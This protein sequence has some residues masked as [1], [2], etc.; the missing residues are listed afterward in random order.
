M[1]R[2]PYWNIDFGILID[3]F[4]V[5]MVI[6]FAYGIYGHWKRICQGK[7]R[8]NPDLSKRPGKIG[9][10][11]VYPLLIKGIIGSR[12]YKKIYTGVAHG[13]LFWGMVIL[14]SGTVLLF[15][16]VLFGI[17]VFRG[18][19]NRWFMSFTLDF[20][21]IAVLCGIIF[22]LIRRLLFPP[23]RLTVPKPRAGF[24]PIVF[25]L[26]VVIITGFMTE[27]ARIA[28][29][30]IDPYS[31]IGNFLSAISGESFASLSLHRYLWWSHGFLAMVFMA[32][33][34]YSPLVHILL[35]PVNAALA[36]PMPGTKMGVIDFS[37]FEDENAEEMPALGAATLTDL[38]RKRLLDYSTCLWCGRCHE[39]CPAA[40]TGKPL[41]PK[42]V[43]LTLGE[44]LQDGKTKD[45]SLIDAVTSEA[46][47]CCTTCAACM[48]AC[49]ALIN[50]PKT[51]LK[52]RQ[53]LVMER[54][55][56]PELMG[57]AN[58]SLELRGHPFFGTGA[59]PKDWSKDLDVPIFKKGET[60]Y[61]LWIGCSVTYEERAHQIARS[62]VRILKYASTSF[63]ILED[64][65]CTGDPA[66]QMG[67]EFLFSEL[68]QQNIEDFSA[69]GIKKIITMCPHCYNSF[70]RHYPLL[71]GN[72]EVIPHSVFIKTLMETGKLQI[73]S[74]SETICYHDPCYLGR[75][76]AIFDE[77]RNVVNSIGNL[78]EM[79]RNR[80]ESF[81]CGGGGGN[82][83]SEEV[84]TRINQV[85]A[86]EA[87]DTKADFIATSCP[88]C[89]LMLTDG[90]KKFTEDQ[91]IF[92]I[93][94]L[95]ALQI[96]ES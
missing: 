42:G 63:G 51:I 64:A 67:N 80:N 59:G 74:G 84:G 17:P 37:S 49:P 16:N 1:E 22:F 68:A 33:I 7:V 65:R 6:I 70:I 88:F 73:N 93:A 95:V 29:T 34:P 47:F 31:F 24:I 28:C 10:V 77:P 61:L 4:A 79:P 13:A 92:D 62:M 30:S 85:R 23:E 5:L 9:P 81:C 69:M 94:E 41:S 58:S 43:I 46:L 21:G 25:L 19:F 76:N 40:Q 54:S 82:Y 75:R 39:V 38:T 56:I 35:V 53:N 52:L 3:A 71:G 90:S 45:D 66:K 87:L 11:Y 78:V 27:S 50:Q 86:K 14:L 57:K 60:E 89:L 8:I 15:L 36:N 12:I 91:K 32:Y 96:M 2:I 83:W 44:F 48:E 18:G 55:E 26:G 20:A 72:Y